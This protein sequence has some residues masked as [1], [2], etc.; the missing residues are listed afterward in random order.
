MR[1]KLIGY[2]ALVLAV[3]YVMSDPT[4]AAGSAKDALGTAGE[5]ADA[6]IQFFKALST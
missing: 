1:N 3:F 6:L 5:V 4:G 2:G